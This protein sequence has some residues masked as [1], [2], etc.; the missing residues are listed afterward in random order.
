[1]DTTIDMAQTYR[2]TL[3]EIGFSVAGLGRA[4]EELVKAAGNLESP[5]VP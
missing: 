4:S 2:E 1:M 3:R 5:K